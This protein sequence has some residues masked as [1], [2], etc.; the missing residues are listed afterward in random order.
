[1][2]T[3]AS[4]ASSS[5]IERANELQRALTDSTLQYALWRPAD[6][7]PLAPKSEGSNVAEAT[8]IGEEA[9]VS[10]T[11][12]DYSYFQATRSRIVDPV[13]TEQK[14]VRP[15]PD[16]FIA[17]QTWEGHVLDVSGDSFVARLSDS[18][19]DDPEEEAEFPLD[20]ISPIDRDLIAPGAVFYWSVGYRDRSNGQRSRESVIRFR[21]LPAWSER[22]LADARERANELLDRLSRG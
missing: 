13:T 11:L 21:R 6:F 7:R 9:I 18:T 12:A 14:S 10:Q 19:G 5:E 22:E 4:A 1:M 16:S 17:L 3:V 15:R 8:L 20:E 2:P